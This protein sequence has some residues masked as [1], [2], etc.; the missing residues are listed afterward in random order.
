LTTREVRVFINLFDLLLGHGDRGLELVVLFRGPRPSQ[1]RQ[2]VPPLL[3]G[4]DLQGPAQ[5][6]DHRVIQRS[7]QPHALTLEGLGQLQGYVVVGEPFH[8]APP[9][10]P[11]SMRRLVPP[12]PPPPPPPPGGRGGLRRPRHNVRR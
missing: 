10:S 4:A 2:T 9:G 3:R 6:L 11:Y 12:P 8:G 1:A 5:Q 7:V